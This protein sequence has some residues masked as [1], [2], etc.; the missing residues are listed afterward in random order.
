M[1]V[2]AAA[3][4]IIIIPLRMAVT[5]GSLWIGGSRPRLTLAMRQ[6][7]PSCS[8]CQGRTL[9]GVLAHPTHS[10]LVGR[11]GGQRLGRVLGCFLCLVSLLLIL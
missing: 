5:Q 2:L 6:H 11:R 8:G 7:P 1:K 9:W 10:V 4:I 3:V